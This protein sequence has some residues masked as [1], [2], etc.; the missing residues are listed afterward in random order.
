MNV[1]AVSQLV[2]DLPDRGERRDALDQAMTCFLLAAGFL[3]FPVPNCLVTRRGEIPADTTALRQ[4]LA[5]LAPRAIVLSGGD[6]FGIRE[7]RDATEMALLDHASER[8]LPMLGLCRG[9]QVMGRWAGV[10]TKLAP[11]HVRVRHEI[12]GAIS[13]RVNSFHRSALSACPS[14]FEVTA[15]SDDGEIEAIRHRAMSWEG[16]MWHPER[17]APFDSRDVGRIRALFSSPVMVEERP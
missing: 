8:E 16:W 17:E 14:G 10:S 11:G 13:G 1:V 7:D 5:A 15:V 4:W 2:E 12:R 9:M 3:A 6:D